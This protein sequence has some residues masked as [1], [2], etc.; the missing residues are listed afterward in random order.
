MIVVVADLTNLVDP[1]LSVRRY[2]VMVNENRDVSD[3]GLALRSTLKHGH[4]HQDLAAN[5][6]GGVV[7][8]HADAITSLLIELGHLIGNMLNFLAVR[9]G[10]GDVPGGLDGA[11]GSPVAARSQV[12]PPPAPRVL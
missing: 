10:G 5:H 3:K 1:L 4:V 2:Q 12:S 6:D 7:G 8:T 9:Y 11:R